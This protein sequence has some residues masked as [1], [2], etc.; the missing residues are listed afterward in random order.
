MPRMFRVVTVLTL[1]LMSLNAFAGPFDGLIPQEEGPEA[2]AV[3]LMRANRAGDAVELLKSELVKQPKSPRLHYYLGLAYFQDGKLDQAEAEFRIVLKEDSQF[4]DAHLRLAALQV[5]RI[6]KTEDR[7]EKLQHLN[8]AIQEVESAIKKNPHNTRLYYE[9]AELY[10]GTAQFLEKNAESGYLEALKVL[11]RARERT[12]E[13][14][15][16]YMARGNVR[17]AQADFVRQQRP[18]DEMKDPDLKK[19]NDIV[20][21]AIADYR[22]VLSINPRS[23]G[24]L[25]RIADIMVSRGD[26]KDAIALLEGHTAKLEAP[27]E[28]AACYRWMGQYLIAANDL[29]SA[30]GKLNRAIEL[31]AGEL[32]SHILL[33][34]VLVRRELPDQAIAQL[35]KSIEANPNFLNAYVEIALI[36]QQ[37]R[38]LDQ[39]IEF[40]KKAMDLPPARAV[41]AARGNK[42]VQ[43]T[44]AELYTLAA[45]RLGNIHVSQNH[46]DEA[47]AVF[48]RLA[49]LMPHSPLPEFHIG[50]VHRRNNNF[51]NAKEHYQNA[52]RRDPN[53]GQARAALAELEVMETRYATNDKERA[54]IL[55]RAI[56]QYEMALKSL[57]DNAM[58]LDRI[59]ALH[60]ELARCSRPMDR[61]VMEKALARA[62]SAVEL[63]PEGH[64]FRRRLADIHQQLG[65]TKQAIAELDKIVEAAEAIVKKSPDNWQAAFQLAD[66]LTLRQR[67]MPDP[68]VQQRALDG[69]LEVSKKNPDFLPAYL[70]AAMI[71]EDM[72]QHDKSTEL[73]KVLLE[74]AKG[75][76]A[77][78]ALPPERAQLALH[79]AA[80]LAWIYCEY[81]NDLDQADKFA[82]IALQINNNLPSL[83]DT[84]GRIHYKAGRFG[85]AIIE[86]RR[87]FKGAPTNATIGFHLAEALVKNQNAER[88]KDILTQIKPYV[89]DELR[90]RYDALVKQVGG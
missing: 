16:P 56:E 20:A 64:Q 39:A 49:S 41:V 40:F 53:Y 66:L 3:A 12:P 83:I 38:N 60:V 74:K 82:K 25:N 36:Q 22:K 79:G 85:E 15:Q 76:S 28:K 14:V 50:E 72:K 81:L 59:A 8:A 37:R 21:A 62:K 47:I 17:V 4:V 88:A 84:V 87:A 65:D 10:V 23:L 45:V 70:R 24:A 43:T 33:A 44:L 51:A 86:L 54:T 5:Q 57:P 61:A 32:A 55:A 18:L 31:D 71:Y 13:E 78:G 68:K 34:S 75:D 35:Q 89:T 6:R 48:R 58:L 63:A 67:W 90:P 7:G 9:A 46:F 42:P 26:L 30:E 2:R 1:V 29:S 52:L 73:Y 69:F 77:Y 11:D 19:Y 27:G 80:E